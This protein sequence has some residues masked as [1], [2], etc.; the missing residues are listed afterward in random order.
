MRE[1]AYQQLSELSRGGAEIFR[2]RLKFLERAI[3]NIICI[4]PKLLSFI[5]L[6]SAMNC[7][8]Q[9]FSAFKSFNRTCYSFWG[10]SMMCTFRRIIMSTPPRTQKTGMI[11]QQLPN[12]EINSQLSKGA[13]G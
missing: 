8:A 13:M 9:L 12:Y 10:P 2:N 3:G 6:Y 5:V 7:P 4:L 11:G 1:L